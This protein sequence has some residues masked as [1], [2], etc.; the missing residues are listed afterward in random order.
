[1]KEYA[2]EAPRRG[3]IPALLEKAEQATARNSLALARTQAPVNEPQAATNLDTVYNF[4]LI[5]LCS[6]HLKQVQRALRER[7]ECTRAPPIIMPVSRELNS[8]ALN[9]HKAN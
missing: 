8:R 1:M 6:V 4:E 5:F 3:E 7:N 9:L 2:N